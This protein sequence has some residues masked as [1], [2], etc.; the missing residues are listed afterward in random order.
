MYLFSVIITTYNSEH[1]IQ[2][3]IN[4][5]VNQQGINEKFSI[6]LIIIDD[7]STD[8]TYEILKSKGYKVIQ[9]PKNSGGPNKGRNIGLSLASGDFICINDHDDVWQN[10]R[11]IK[12]LPYINKAPIISCGYIVQ[13]SNRTY[14]KVNKSSCFTYYEKNQTFLDILLRK[15]IRQNVYLSGL[16]ISKSLKHIT[17]EEEY[18]QFDFDWLLRL[19]ENQTSFE[20][21]LPLFIRNINGNNLSLNLKYREQDFY[22][23]KFVINSLTLKYPQYITIA[24][25][26]LNNSYA[27]YLY[28]IGNSKLSRAYFRN[29]EFTLKNILYYLTTFCGQNYIRKK[30]R[31][32]G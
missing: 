21:A 22:F 15:K 6:E 24:I 28:L 16:I 29:S 7:C 23:N 26:R 12:T 4:S 3:T 31:I 32:F 30:I 18:G 8:Q 20:I 9:N 14:K 10:D 25:K 19:F 11:I 27:K 1:F 5:I 13:N 17:F 2:N